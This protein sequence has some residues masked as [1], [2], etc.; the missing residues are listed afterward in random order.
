MVCVPARSAS[1]PVPFTYVDNRMTIQCTINGTGPL[2]MIVDTG[3]PDFA[4]DTNAA[5]LLGLRVRNNGTVSGAGNKA[6]EIGA[7]ELRKVDI[8]TQSFS[9]VPASVLDLSEIRMK[10]GFPRLDGVVGYSIMKRFAVAVDVDEQTISFLPQPPSIPPSAS[11]TSFAGVIP[12]V[13]A[14]IDGIAT[15]VLIDTGDR[16]SLTLFGPFAKKHNFYAKASQ[17]NIVTGYGLGGPVYGD[18]FTLPSLTIFGRQLSAVVTRA[19]RQTGGVFTESEQGGSIGEGVLKRFNIIYD[20]P[21][22]KIIAWP[23]KAFP[24]PDRFIPPPSTSS[25]SAS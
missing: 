20:Y 12:I 21:N 1:T 16:S 2:T 8:G 11:K 15:K 4:V 14:T 10:L 3:S 13:A 24:Q 7:T 23:S 18:V 25:R 22:Q 6:V 17:V 5:H 19:S 9:N